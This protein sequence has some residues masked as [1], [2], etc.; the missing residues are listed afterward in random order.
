MSRPLPR[1]V[2]EV[3]RGV[4]PLWIA[5]TA[6]LFIVW[7]YELIPQAIRMLGHSGQ[8]ETV[9]WGVY[10]SLLVGFPVVCI[11]IGLVVPRAINAQ[12]ATMVKAFAIVV[13]I[14]LAIKFVVDGRILLAV[15]ALVPTIIATLLSTNAYRIMSERPLEGLV[16]LI[17]LGVVSLIAWMS[18]GGMVYWTRATDWFLASPGRILAFAVAT[19][20]SISGL[21]RVGDSPET[22]PPPGVAFRIASV[23]LL[24]ILIVFSFRTNPVVEFYHW[25]FWVG[26]IEQLRQGGWLMGHYSGKA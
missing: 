5:A 3:A 19:V 1:W 26:P 23:F 11:L 17:V 12:A 13:A 7:G 25:G 15:I 18:A 20:V 6:T 21:P 22:K 16:A 8:T 10:M 2:T 14:L 4:E 24:L 9:E